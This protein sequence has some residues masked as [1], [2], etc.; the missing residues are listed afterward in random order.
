MSEEF[1]TVDTEF[2]REKTYYPKLCLV[3]IAGN[4]DAFAIDVLAQGIDLS[5]FYA[6]MQDENIVK[7]FH[8]AS[9]DLEIFV[10][11]NGK[12]PT[13]LY[14]T[15]I[16]A[17]V[18]GFGEAVGYAAIVNI[19][20]KV[21]IDKAVR[22]TD[23]S[24]R[25]LTDKQIEYAISDVTHLREIY[26][27][28]E[29]KLEKKERSKWAYEEIKKT[30]NINSY[31]VDVEEIWRKIKIRG[32]SGRYIAIV[33]ELAKWRE[34]RAQKS[35]KPRSWI[36]SDDAILELAATCPKSIGEVKKLRFYKGSISGYI[37]EILQVIE[38][39]KNAAPT[40]LK[41]KKPLSDSASEQ[42]DLLKLL[43]KLQ[44]AK[45]DIAPS[46]IAKS[47]DIVA[48][49]QNKN[50]EIPAS[51]QGWRYDVFGQYAEKLLKGELSL[52][53]QNGRI[54]ILGD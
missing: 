13:P 51:M 18:L 54:K 36:L 24:K 15:Q 44:A 1:V 46:V 49:V 9:Q 11:E 10:N 20:C 31:K 22:H 5:P 42:V 30:A 29:E 37:D 48:L 38:V 25:P 17:Q 40:E 23:W 21:T 45:H 7:V 4:D 14:D 32:G 28:L 43:L 16:A 8:A 47:D 34:N 33:K 39:G 41:K 35:D 12:V 52:S 26:M 27:V 19:I 53:I 2:L 50:D 6:L 3:Q